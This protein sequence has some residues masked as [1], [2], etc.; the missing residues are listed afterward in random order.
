MGFSVLSIP[1]L[2]G[3]AEEQASLLSCMACTAHRGC[4]AVGTH[5]GGGGLFFQW[6]HRALT[7]LQKSP[8][9]LGLKKH[10]I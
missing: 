8:R 1:Q 5:R 10:S 6:E 3:N 9:L 2:L 7:V 4:A